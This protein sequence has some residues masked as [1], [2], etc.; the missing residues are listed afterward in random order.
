MSRSILRAQAPR[1][2]L[3]SRPKRGRRAGCSARGAQPFPAPP[4][5][6]HELFPSETALA[7]ARTSP[8]CKMQLYRYSRR[9]KGSQKVP[10][11]QVP[12]KHN[13]RAQ[14][15]P[16]APAPAGTAAAL[17]EPPHVAVLVGE[18]AVGVIAAV[19]DVLEAAAEH[20]S[21]VAARP[22]AAEP[23]DQH[24]VGVEVTA[25][26][27]A[28]GAAARPLTARPA[29]GLGCARAGGEASREE[30]RR[31]ARRGEERRG[32]GGRSRAG[33]G[34]RWRR[35]RRAHCP[36]GRHRA[37]AARALRAGSGEGTAP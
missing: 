26:L 27:G 11:L 12:H 16:G 29:P 1:R 23:A 34:L 22:R 33:R 5:Q 20:G 36:R 35:D 19:L 8:G 30:R 9:D 14:L 7:R 17:P 2:P 13:P 21:G 6:H 24:L 10:G 25:A 3:P 31:E 37:G 4:Y 32:C 15:P 18:E 28:H